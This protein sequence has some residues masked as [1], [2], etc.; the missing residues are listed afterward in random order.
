MSSP[1]QSRSAVEEHW[2]KRLEAAEARFRLSKSLAAT[3]VREQVDGLTPSPDGRLGVSQALRDESEALAEY[4]HV[5]RVFNRLVIF[6]ELPE[7]SI[8][9]V[10]A[11]RP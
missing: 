8:G 7:E 4:C 10:P 1:S 11:R 5:L 6:G 9:D 3:A 2:R